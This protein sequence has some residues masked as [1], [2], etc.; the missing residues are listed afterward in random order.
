MTSLPAP[1][2][3]SVRQFE[4]AS[5]RVVDW[6]RRRRYKWTV[7]I[8]NSVL[9]STSVHTDG[10]GW[11][12]ER[13]LACTLLYFL[14]AQWIPDTLSKFFYSGKIHN[15]LQRQL[16][17]VINQSESQFQWHFLPSPIRFAHVTAVCSDENDDQVRHA[18]E[19]VWC[20]HKPHCFT[21]TML[22]SHLL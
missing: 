15:R 13:A 19:Y 14:S 4:R 8:V 2:S 16:R 12:G 5:A 17:R 3:A 20:S 1:P 22:N 18:L 11:A 7:I 9:N 6:L 10:H 21:L